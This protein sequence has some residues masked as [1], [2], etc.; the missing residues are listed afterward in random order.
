MICRHTLCSCAAFSSS[1]PSTPPTINSLHKEFAHCDQLSARAGSHADNPRARCRA[2]N[3]DRISRPARAF[4]SSNSA[5]CS[6]ASRSSERVAED[7]VYRY[8]Q[9]SPKFRPPGFI[10][11]PTTFRP[12]PPT[13]STPVMPTPAPAEPPS[14]PAATHSASKQIPSSTE[15]APLPGPT[16]PG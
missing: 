1:R 16:P 14:Q 13:R 15:T 10:P 5:P 11:P 8:T 9:S 12:Y 6:S 4:G 3:A 2:S 7:I